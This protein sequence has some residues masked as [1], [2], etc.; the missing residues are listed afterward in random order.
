MTSTNS[1]IPIILLNCIPIVGV[2]FYGWAPFEMFWLFWVETLIIA[3]FNAIRI[4]FA[5]NNPADQPF[6]STGNKYNKFMSVRY[7]FA[8][9]GIFL[10][11]SIFIIVFIGILGSKGRGLETLGSIFFQDILFN[12]A[13]IL[14]V[15]NQ[16][17][18]LVKFYFMNQAYF[19]DNPKYYT[20][21]FDGRQIVMHIAIIIGS[22]GA[23][24]LFKEDDTAGYGAI[25]MISILCLLKILYEIYTVKL[26]IP[27]P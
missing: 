20:A 25:W 24:F 5:Q 7:L 2:A 15:V 17:F 11:Y 23:A 4:F 1:K 19:Y 18:Y 22:F 16:T 12:L 26:T 10:F 13:L 14:I 6:S 8:R 9:I 27:N 21:I 3:L